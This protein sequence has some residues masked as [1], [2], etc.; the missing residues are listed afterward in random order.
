LAFLGTA[1]Y[2]QSFKGVPS[3]NPLMGI[4]VSA[5]Q[6]VLIQVIQAL[7]IGSL[8]PSAIV[9]ALLWKLYG[10]FN[11]LSEKLTRVELKIDSLEKIIPYKI[12]ECIDQIEKP[13]PVP[14]HPKHN[15]NSD[16]IDF[17]EVIGIAFGLV[18][19]LI[20]FGLFYIGGGSLLYYVKG[21]FL[22]L[23]TGIFGIFPI[24]INKRKISRGK[25]A[26]FSLLSV[27]PWIYLA[28]YRLGLIPSLF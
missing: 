4:R 5:P 13:E 14:K 12:K 23:V 8:I 15:P 10:F 21:G 3:I 25:R 27:V 17:V 20:F 16:W 6:D 19:F 26:L 7:N 2:E 24:I 22:F 9:I 11:D 18:N 28:L 1:N